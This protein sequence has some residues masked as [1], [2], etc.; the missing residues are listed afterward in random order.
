MSIND[1]FEEMTGTDS[2]TLYAVICDGEVY[3]VMDDPEEALETLT[4]EVGTPGKVVVLTAMVTDMEVLWT[5]DENG[6]TT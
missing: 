3:G 6:E 1:T 5:T 2:V 4:A